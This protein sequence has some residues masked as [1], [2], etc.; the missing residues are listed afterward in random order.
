MS[1][2]YLAA[3]VVAL[4]AVLMLETLVPLHPSANPPVRRWVRNLALSALAVSVTLGTPYLI[5]ALVPAGGWGPTHSGLT[6]WGWPVWAQ[7]LLTFLAMEAAVYALHRLSHRWPWLWRLHAVHHSD[8][9]LDVTTTHRHH[10]LENLLSVLWVL[11]IWL[12]LRP[13]LGAMLSYTLLAVVVS[14]WSHGNLKLPQRVDRVLRLLIVTPAYHRVHHS[15]HQAQT[16]SNYAT[17]LTVFDHLFRTASAAPSDSG[18]SLT[19]GLETEREP[20]HQSLARLLASPFTT[21]RKAK[22]PR[23]A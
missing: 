13:P 16:D 17:V 21:P 14:T 8:T 2:L 10:P 5:R 3:V 12:L 20:Q 9:E 19:M 7:W 4:C 6:T 1:H 11:P 22:R 15:A 18:H 23:T